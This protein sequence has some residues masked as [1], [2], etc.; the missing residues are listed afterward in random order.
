MNNEEKA[1]AATNLIGN[2]VKLISLRY[3]T[4]SKHSDG[5]HDAMKSAMDIIRDAMNGRCDDPIRIAYDRVE[6]EIVKLAEKRESGDMSNE[7]LLAAH[8]NM[9]GQTMGYLYARS[10]LAKYIKKDIDFKVE[11]VQC[12]LRR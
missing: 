3:G 1:K 9:R 8:D 5:M 12:L 11:N 6:E 10:V 2:R 7:D 4:G